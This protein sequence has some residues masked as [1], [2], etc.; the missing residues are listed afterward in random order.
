[1]IIKGYCKT[2]SHVIGMD[3]VRENKCTWNAI[4]V[5]GQWQ[6]VHPFLIC[7]PLSQQPPTEGWTLVESSIEE[8]PQN[9]DT[10][11]TFNGFFFAPKP[12]DFIHICIPEENMHN[13]QLLEKPIAYSRFLELPFLRSVFYARRFTLVEE[14][15]CKGE[16]KTQ[17]GFISIRIR[18]VEPNLKDSEIKYDLY[19]SNE[20]NDTQKDE[21]C[22]NFVF[23]GR[24][25]DTW[26]IQIRCYTVGVFKLSLYGLSSE[27]FYWLCD[28]MIT[29]DQPIEEIHRPPS[30][31]KNER[32][33][34]TNKTEEAG[35]LCASHQGGVI[36]FKP[37]ENHVV[38]F[39]IN[40]R[41]RTHCE[42]EGAVL[43]PEEL[44]EYV[45]KTIHKNEMDFI[46]NLPFSGEYLLKIFVVDES[47]QNEKVC[48]YWLTDADDTKTREVRD[49]EN[50]SLDM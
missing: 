17:N 1:M 48:V 37:K 43:S 5:D 4:H 24:T 16:L 7:T 33:G 23:C 39:L 21:E 10:Y 45:K 30:I 25:E 41:I 19:R 12:C 2:A 26:T 8:R 49:H 35:L 34:P 42:L 20:D 22:G 13:W 3:G 36:F 44:A 47:E 50:M 32:L 15:T 14:D 18:G 6:L 46:F 38:K 27:W 11:A 40:R 28:F 31:S 9:T 29:C